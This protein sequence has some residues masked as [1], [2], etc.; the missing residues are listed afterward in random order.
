MSYVPYNNFPA[1]LHEGERVL[2][3]SQAR[4]YDAGGPLSVTI[5][6]GG[7]SARMESRQDAEE[8]ARVI[9]EE[10]AQALETV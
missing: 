8:I 4:Q 5:N 2:T 7:V 10:V 1:L 6:L 3:A 9:A